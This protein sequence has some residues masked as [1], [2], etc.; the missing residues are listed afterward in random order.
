MFPEM[1]RFEGFLKSQ[2]QGK[3]PFEEA[4]FANSNE[5]ATE[6]ELKAEREYDEKL[7]ERELEGRLIN[8]NLSAR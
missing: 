2:S 3:H 5:K 7:Y 1:P 8:D 6:E 4:E